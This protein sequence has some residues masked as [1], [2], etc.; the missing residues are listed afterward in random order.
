[1]KRC[2]T[3]KGRKR[4]SKRKYSKRK[5]SKRKYS[6]RK[7]SKRKYSKRIK[8]KG[9]LDSWDQFILGPPPRKGP[10]R[11]ADWYAGR[12]GLTPSARKNIENRKERNMTYGRDVG[13]LDVLREWIGNY[14]S[15]DEDI[16]DGRPNFKKKVIEHLYNGFM[17]EMNF[18][19]TPID[20]E[21]VKNADSSIKKDIIEW[22]FNGGDDP[23]I[24]T[25]EEL[26][27][28]KAEAELQKAIEMSLQPENM[29]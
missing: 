3:N 29:G 5:Y 10:E 27:S 26:E 22:L 1:M 8:Y 23:N 21:I 7:Y 19:R 4:Y 9:G 12:G 17:N 16:R 14:P 24:Y 25:K 11:D 15:Q 13:I 28:R 2:K 18:T 6:K 20:Y